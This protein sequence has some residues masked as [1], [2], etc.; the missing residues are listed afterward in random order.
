[1]AKGFINFL[2]YSKSRWPPQ[3]S[4]MSLSKKH[5]FIGLEL[6]RMSLYVRFIHRISFKKLTYFKEFY[7]Q[8]HIES[9]KRPDKTLHPVLSQ[10][11]KSLAFKSIR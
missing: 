7:I 8:I 4:D 1:M 5:H 11:D 10:C 9:F 2:I 3:V 6:N